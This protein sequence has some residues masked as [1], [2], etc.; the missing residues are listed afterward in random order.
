MQLIFEDGWMDEEQHKEQ[1]KFQPKGNLQ[2]RKEK[3]NF[4]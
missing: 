2:D 1:E 3:Q 4:D